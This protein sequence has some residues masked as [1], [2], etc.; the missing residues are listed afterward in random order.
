MEN[1]DQPKQEPCTLLP[2]ASK[3]SRGLPN[4]IQTPPWALKAFPVWA[5]PLSSLCPAAPPVRHTMKN[6]I[7]ATVDPR[8]CK[9]LCVSYLL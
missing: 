9:G 1:L 4:S 6:D 5:Q 8:L 2:E 3:A 7:K